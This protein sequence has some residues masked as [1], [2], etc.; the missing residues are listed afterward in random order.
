M[1][2]SKRNSTPLSYNRPVSIGLISF[3][4][5]KGSTPSFTPDEHGWAQVNDLRRSGS[6]ADL[7]RGVDLQA[8]RG[9]VGHLG[10]QA[11]LGPGACGGDNIEG[12]VSV[13][14]D[15]NSSN[16]S[17]TCRFHGVSSSLA[18]PSGRTI[19]PASA[20]SRP[21]RSSW[22]RSMGVPYR[23]PQWFT[24]SSGGGGK[25]EGDDDG[26]EEAPSSSSSRI[27]L[28][29]ASRESGSGADCSAASLEND[30][31]EADDRS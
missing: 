9:A 12:G 6:L 11:Q 15:A 20:L 24:N 29:Q 25:R 18:L 3:M 31:S 7:F 2:R 19:P 4:L 1:L 23:R 22:E 28:L 27:P 8:S 5:F 14:R 13:H 10:P 21:G 17:I 30:N 16:L 26:S